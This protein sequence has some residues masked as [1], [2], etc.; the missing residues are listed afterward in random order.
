MYVQAGYFV[1]PQQ[2]EFA[3]RFSYAD[4]DDGKVGGQC[5]GNDNI[6]QASVVANYYFW[7]QHLKAQVGYDIVRE[8][9]YETRDNE[10]TNKWMVGISTWW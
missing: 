2:L 3:S 10:N 6:K 7:G 4:C 5:A 1:L 9:D 8:K